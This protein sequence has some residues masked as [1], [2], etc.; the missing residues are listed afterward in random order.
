MT[1]PV[2]PA[3]NVTNPTPVE[4]V[5]SVTPD[6]NAANKVED[7]PQWAQAHIAELRREGQNKGQ[8]ITALE[9]ELTTT[10]NDFATKEAGFAQQ[11]SNSALDNARYRAAVASGVPVDKIDDFASR[12]R[13][14]TPEELATDAASLAQLFPSAPAAPQILN[15]VD[16][17]LG[18]GNGTQAPVTPGAQL[19]E[20]VRG[21]LGRS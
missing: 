14:S 10:R 17:S 8:R 3:T 12:L 16:P 13:G 11:L 19:A 21:Q 5:T 9:G 18:L 1:G 4:P 6:P 15:G 20:L 7:L 2:V